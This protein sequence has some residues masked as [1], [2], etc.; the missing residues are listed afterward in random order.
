MSVSVAFVK[1]HAKRMRH[2]ILSSVANLILKHFSKLSHKRH[3]FR[4][5]HR[6]RVLIFSTNIVWNILREI[7]PITIRNGHSSSCKVPVILV[8]F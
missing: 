3:D 5:K 6:M 4:E 2:I 1:Q 8:R 7:P